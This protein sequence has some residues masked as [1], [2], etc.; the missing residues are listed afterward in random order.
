MADVPATDPQPG[1]AD[2]YDGFGFESID[3]A[4]ARTDVRQA[5]VL[6]GPT[7]YTTPTPTAR[8]RL[9]MARSKPKRFGSVVIMPAGK[10]WEL[11]VEPCFEI[12]ALDAPAIRPAQPIES[13]HT[14]GGV[15]SRVSRSCRQKRY[16]AYFST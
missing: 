3:V 5:I 2:G 13:T 16:S 15:A 8:T 11:A 6:V 9:R 1:T 12:A 4:T 10:D 7:P 14:A